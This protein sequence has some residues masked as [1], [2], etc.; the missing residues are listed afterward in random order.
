MG[1]IWSRNAAFPLCLIG[2]VTIVPAM[3]LSAEVVFIRHQLDSAFRSEGVAVADFNGD[4]HLDVAAGNVVYTGPDWKICPILGAPRQFKQKG[5][6]DAF[7]CFA[8]DINGD[9]LLDIVT[10][11]KKGVYVFTQQR[12]D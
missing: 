12:R 8:D 9:G 1:A 2:S 6:S 7:L 5:Y 4:S 11:N 3:V 10:A